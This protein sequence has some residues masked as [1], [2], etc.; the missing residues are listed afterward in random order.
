MRD[1]I[2]TTQT[3]YCFNG[4]LILVI[5]Y[6]EKIKEIKKWAKFKETF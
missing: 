5:A 2:A 4:N 3:N 1:K 6:D